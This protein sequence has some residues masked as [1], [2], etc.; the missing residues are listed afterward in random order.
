MKV[1]D[2][3]PAPKDHPAYK[4]GPVVGGIRIGYS[5]KTGEHA[6]QMKRPKPVF[7]V[8]DASMSGE[9]TMSGLIS[10]LRKSGFKISTE[11]EA[12]LM[13]EVRAEDEEDPDGI[14]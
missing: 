7:A 10:A 4:T 1:I 2:N 8:S 6:S 5:S 3:G 9:Q 12:E 11:T 14:G 13:A